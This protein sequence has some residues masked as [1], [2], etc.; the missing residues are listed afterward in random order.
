MGEF[1]SAR[2][3]LSQAN[4]L[5]TKYCIL[6]RSKVPL[7]VQV[8]Y[9]SVPVIDKKYWPRPKLKKAASRIWGRRARPKAQAKRKPTKK[10]TEPR[11]ICWIHW[12]VLSPAKLFQAI[13]E[14]DSMSLLHHPDFDWCAFWERASEEDWGRQHP[15]VKN[16]DAKARARAIAATFH[17]DEGEGKR[18][19]NTLILSWSSIGVHGPSSLT[20]FPFCAAW[21]VF[22]DITCSDPHAFIPSKGIGRQEVCLCCVEAA[23]QACNPVNV[24]RRT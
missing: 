1:A 4:G 10:D 19:R 2:N 9:V 17:G 21:L 16:F 14:S 7:K 22:S 12:P 8:T 24:E 13:V 20:K 5:F 23:F 15:V 18:G 11:R 6:C 3:I